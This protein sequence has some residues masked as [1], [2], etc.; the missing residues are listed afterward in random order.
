MPPSGEEA[1]AQRKATIK[2]FVWLV[3]GLAVAAAFVALLHV[4]TPFQQPAKVPP[5]LPAPAL[6]APPQKQIS[7]RPPGAT[8]GHAPPERALS[9]R[10]SA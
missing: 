1:R 2:P 7:R 8:L 5:P 10:P 3:L 4:R 9:E 6:T